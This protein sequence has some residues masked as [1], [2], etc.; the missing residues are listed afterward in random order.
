MDCL[1]F[2]TDSCH[3]CGDGVLNGMEVCDG[4]DLGVET[5]ETQGYDLGGTLACTQ[6]CTF[7]TDNCVSSC[8]DGVVNGPNEECDGADLNGKSCT[9]EGYQGGTLTCNPDCTLSKASC[10]KAAWNQNQPC[11][12]EGTCCSNNGCGMGGSCTLNGTAVCC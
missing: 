5:C 2:N 6:D 4:A 7:D 8:G 3:V 11:S 9:G 10:C 1:S 12:L